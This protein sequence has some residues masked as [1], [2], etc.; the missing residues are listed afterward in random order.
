[1]S[2]CL[3][4]CTKQNEFY[5]IIQNFTSKQLCSINFFW[6]RK[7]LKD[8]QLS[9]YIPSVEKLNNNSLQ[10]TFYSTTTKKENLIYKVIN[11]KEYYEESNFFLYDIALKLKNI[12]FLN[13]IKE[14]SFI[15][16]FENDILIHVWL[17]DFT[18]STSLEK[19]HFKYIINEN[20]QYGSFSNKYIFFKDNLVSKQSTIACVIHIGNVEVYK[21]YIEIYIQRLTEVGYFIHLFYTFFSLE[22]KHKIKNFENTTSTYIQVENK[23]M[24]IGAFFKVIEYWKKNNLEYDFFL[25]LHTKSNKIWR[26]NLINPLVGS[27][28]TIKNN[29]WIMKNVSKV[30]LIGSKDWLLK[31]DS[32]NKNT[33]QKIAKQMHF[34]ESALKNTK[35]IGGTMFWMRFS[36]IDV[37]YNNIHFL[38][39][40]YYN[41]KT[42]YI[43]NNIETNTHSW[44]R[45]L[46]TLVSIK[47]LIYIGI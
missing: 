27:Y 14:N 18:A 46:G 13:R 34:S 6:I 3:S 16:V 37:L 30:G 31:L 42:G 8:Q 44:E 7:C 41:M 38:N 28:E 39:D 47:K 25:K 11:I 15:G 45:L 12:C 10:L 26:E 1:M 9:K 20:L 5:H 32:L 43:V 19:Y 23:G 40:M 21:K 22:T 4:E 29:I 24:D 33:Q 2:Y 36:C 17:I 35:F